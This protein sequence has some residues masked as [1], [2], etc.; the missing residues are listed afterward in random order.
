[1]N[2]MRNS[3]Y[4]SILHKEKDENGYT[5]RLF[6]VKIFTKKQVFQKAENNNERVGY[7]SKFLE[8]VDEVRPNTMVGIERLYSLW[9]SVNYIVKNNIDGDIVECGVW[10][11]GCCELIAKTLVSLGSTS[12]KIYMYDTFEGMS[13][14]DEIDVT[15]DG[16]T[17]AKE[18][19]LEMQKEGSYEYGEK[20]WCE[21]PIQ[22]VYSVMVK[23]GYPM[24]NVCLVKGKV[25]DTIPNV[26]PNHICILRLDTD[27][28]ESTKHEMLHLYKNLSQGGVL[29]SDDYYYWAGCKKAID[30]YFS[31]KKK[32]LLCKTE[33]G[34]TAVKC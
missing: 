17:K 30:E 33:S 2:N 12:R 23:T 10:R 7:P 4:G 26:M 32:P 3:K 31:N 18:I 6:G 8:I 19:M 14:P 25:E 22:H 1:M 34:F 16:K 21:S 15:Y 13:V 27:W 11:G 9:C 20:N 24:E 29:I 28:Y 5:I